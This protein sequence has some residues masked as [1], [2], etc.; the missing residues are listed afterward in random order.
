MS[1][2]VNGKKVFL[3]VAETTALEESWAEEVLTQEKIAWLKNRRGPTGYKTIET[4]LDMLYND[5]INN[6][7]TWVDHVADVKTRYPKPEQAE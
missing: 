4:Q 2:M 3:S 5:K 1:K 7:T 6:T